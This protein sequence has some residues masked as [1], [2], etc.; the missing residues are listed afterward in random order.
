MERAQEEMQF[1]GF[2]GIFKESYKLIFSGRKIFSNITLALILPLSFVYLVYAHVY[3]FFVSKF[4]AADYDIPS[5]LISYDWLYF[6]LF[7]AAYFILFSIFSLFSTAAVVYTIAC[8][9]TA[10][11]LAFKEVMSVVPKILK[12]LIVTFFSIFVAIFF[13][14][15]ATVVVLI[16]W[17]ISVGS[18]PTV[19]LTVLA[20]LVIL[21]IVG[22][23]YLTTIWHLASSISVL[24]EAYGF[25]AMVKSK[26]LIKGKL[27]LGIS[28][29]FIL[30]LAMGFNQ[31]AFKR[32]VVEGTNIGMG[33]KIVYGIIFF[34]LLSTMILFGL[35]IQTVIYFVCKSYH[36]ENID[37][38]ALSDHLQLYLLGEYTPSKAKDCQLQVN[39]Y[40]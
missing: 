6:W 35:V 1:L 32:L 39:Q 14:L 13:Y 2:F 25:P 17:A 29:F 38:A 37:K 7:N 34:L 9:Y 21:F 12:R 16:V 24:E 22:F 8:I 27:W 20:I 3:S 10:R 40:K 11:E 15:V 28:I 36:H 26:N 19:G 33:E 30:N 31:I 18:I 23:L 4:T 5:Q